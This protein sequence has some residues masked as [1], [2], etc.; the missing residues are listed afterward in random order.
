ML[1]WRRLPHVYSTT[2]P[3]FLTWRLYGSLPAHRHFGQEPKSS[4]QE[5][6]ALDRLLDQGR[7]GPVHLREPRVA[8]MVVAAIL[9]AADK[10]LFY[11]LHAFVVMPNH[12]H[13]LLTPTVPLPKLLKSIKNFTAK[14]ANEMLSTTGST[15]WQPETYDHVVRNHDEFNRIWAYIER[16]PVRAGLAA[17]PSDYCWSSAGWPTR[18]SAADPAV[19]PT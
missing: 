17:T 13:L 11:D 12:V 19:C 16:N 1:N 3:V 4:G 10:L 9:Y 15:F 7:T 5:F 6:D 14:Q 2:R 18:P 8:D